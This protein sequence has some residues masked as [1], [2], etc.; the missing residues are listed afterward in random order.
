MVPMNW[1]VIRTKPRQELMA[2]FYLRQLPVE[3]FLPL[4]K[5]YKTARSPNKEVTS[6]LFPRYMFAKFNYDQYRAVNFSR[7]VLNVVEFGGKPAQVSET[8]IEAIKSKMKMG[9]VIPQTE[10]F[11]KGQTVQ[12]TEGPFAGL[13]AVFVK[14]LKYQQRVLLLLRALGLHAKLVMDIEHLM[15]AKAL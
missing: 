10:N 3:T 7:G 13:E 1:Y 15:L 14:E 6:P 11:K 9:Y 12:V 8:L 2:Q 5:E 4:I